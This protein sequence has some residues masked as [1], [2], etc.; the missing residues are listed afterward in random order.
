MTT[1]AF[2][3][4]VQ[5]WWAKAKHARYGKPYGQMVYLPMLEANTTRPGRAF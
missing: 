3:T 2:Q 5:D 1:E 4:I